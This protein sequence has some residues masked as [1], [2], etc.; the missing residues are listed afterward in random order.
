M[1]EKYK[2]TYDRRSGVTLE[3]VHGIWFCF[4]R[5]EKKGFE[6]TFKNAKADEIENFY[7]VERDAKVVTSLRLS[8][9]LYKAQRDK[10]I[11]LLFTVCYPYFFNAK[12]SSILFVAFI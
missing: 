1:Y 3:K 6:A 7:S 8:F 12:F 9:E 10:Y 5:S 4:A 2:A 11:A